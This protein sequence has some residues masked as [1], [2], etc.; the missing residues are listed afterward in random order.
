MAGK[1][2]ESIAESML[3]RMCASHQLSGQLL[4]VGRAH[5]L[6]IESTSRMVQCLHLCGS[7][8]CIGNSKADTGLPVVVTGSIT[9]AAASHKHVILLHWMFPLFQ[10]DCA[11]VSATQGPKLEQSKPDPTSRALGCRQLS[12]GGPGAEPKAKKIFLPNSSHRRP[13]A[14]LR[15]LL[16]C[17]FASE[18]D[19]RAIFRTGVKVEARSRKAE[20]GNSKL[21]TTQTTCVTRLSP[22]RRIM[23]CSPRIL[24]LRPCAARQ[25][26]SL[27]Q[28]QEFAMAPASWFHRLAGHQIG[29][30]PFQPGLVISER[31]STRL[32]VEEI[33]R[34][35]PPHPPA[36]GCHQKQ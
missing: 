35:G 21:H 14:K 34:K 5:L 1:S 16:P 13:A 8:T 4:S 20:N 25:S 24:K 23:R 33:L 27:A 18:K 12:S 26:T 22:V 10:A 19:K 6:C 15:S 9:F 17:F 36:Q 30:K 3:I 2:E 7:L 29:S 11:N 31:L 28:G 32:P